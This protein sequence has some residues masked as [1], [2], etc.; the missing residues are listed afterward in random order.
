MMPKEGDNLGIEPIRERL[1]LDDKIMSQLLKLHGIP[2]IY[3]R[4]V[5]P[6][7]EKDKVDD[8]EITPGYNYEWGANGK[9]KVKESQWV[10][11]DDGGNDSYSLLPPPIVVSFI[12]QL[13]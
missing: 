12:K 4:N 3:L 7:S 8:Y 1:E 11:K 2:K 9:V 10:V 13:V 6:V 5:I